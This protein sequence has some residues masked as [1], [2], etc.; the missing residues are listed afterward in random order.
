MHFSCGDYISIYCAI[1]H[2]FKFQYHRALWLE[3]C[4]WHNSSH[5]DDAVFIISCY[6]VPFHAIC[7]FDGLPGS[8]SNSF[9]FYFHNHLYYSLHNLLHVFISAY[10]NA[11]CQVFSPFL[12]WNLFC[13]IDQTSHCQHLCTDQLL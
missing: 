7:I 12:T 10:T 11:S 3:S 5:H 6:Q 1:S 13:I 4:K 2:T 8:S 9:C